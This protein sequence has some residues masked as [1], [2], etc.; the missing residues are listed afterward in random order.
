MSGTHFGATRRL[1]EDS[2]C[3]LQCTGRH[4]WLGAPDQLMHKG[5]L[6][7][8][9]LDP[10]SLGRPSPET[11]SL[12]SLHSDGLLGLLYSRISFFL[13][14]ELGTAFLEALRVWREPH[15]STRGQT[16]CIMRG[17]ES[18]WL[19]Q[20]HFA[21]RDRRPAPK[22][23]CLAPERGPFLVAPLTSRMQNCPE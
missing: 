14:R 4:L 23:G 12:S 10:G 22:G 9:H 2:S 18:L 15:S 8:S 13:L 5:Q 21:V 3:P 16:F 11:L 1:P 6:T 19:F 17:I 20:L 7:R